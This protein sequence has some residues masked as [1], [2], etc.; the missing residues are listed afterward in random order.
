[1]QLLHSNALYAA[2]RELASGTVIYFID[3]SWIKNK[4]PTERYF[5]ANNSKIG[6][7]YYTYGHGSVQNTNNKHE[8]DKE[9]LNYIRLALHLKYIFIQMHFP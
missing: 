9:T 5:W 8:I 6:V 4:I 2:N 7:Y 1:M 3:R